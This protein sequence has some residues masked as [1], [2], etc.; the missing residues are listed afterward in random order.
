V[1][2][3]TLY[4][5]FDLPP[6]ASRDELHARWRALCAQWHPDLPGGGDVERYK[7]LQEAWAVLKDPDA[8][9]LYDRRLAMD[10]GNCAACHGRGRVSRSLSFTKVEHVPCEACAGDGRKRAAGA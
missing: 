10:G 2:A 8:R 4:G 5:E 1:K 9:S 7:R 6:C 3:P